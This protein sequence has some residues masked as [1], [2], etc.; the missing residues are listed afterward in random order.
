MKSSLTPLIVNALKFSAWIME[1]R[2]S[3]RRILKDYLDA[4]DDTFDIY[5]LPA[6]NELDAR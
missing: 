6:T 4:V 2:D 5:D 1:A 3:K